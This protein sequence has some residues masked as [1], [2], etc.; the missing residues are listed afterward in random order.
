[1]LLRLYNSY[2]VSC[3]ADVARFPLDSMNCVATLVVASNARYIQLKAWNSTMKEML[4]FDNS[5][6][7]WI[8]KNLSFHPKLTHVK[9]FDTIF[10]TETL[11]VH[12][13]VERS[14]A[15]Y[16][17]ILQIP[18]FL[19][20]LMIVATTWIP[21]DSGER[22]GFVINLCLS[23]ILFLLLLDSLLPKSSYSAMS[24]FVLISYILSVLNLMEC[25]TITYFQHRYKCRDPMCHPVVIHDKRSTEL[26]ESSPS[27][28]KWLFY[29]KRLDLITFLVD[30]LCLAIML[31]AI[32]VTLLGR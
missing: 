22:I 3:N 27:T 8:V 13:K 1:M 11:Q 17:I 28:V 32:F 9:I 14:P 2:A 19:L 15:Y 26:N 31:I 7:E 10:P 6:S 4:V 25:A 12:I 23:F 24:I 18:M 30:V 16:L 20:A 29:S 21:V 5:G